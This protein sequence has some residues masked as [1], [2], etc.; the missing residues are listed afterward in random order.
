M[1]NALVIKGVSF[2]TNALTTISYGG[3]VPCTALSLNQSSVTITDMSAYTLTA[4]PTPSNTSDTVSWSSSD[5]N[6]ATVAD[7]VVTPVR[8]GSVT[9]TATCGTQTAT[10]AFTIRQYLN[11]G[12]TYYYYLGKAT[13]ADGD[14]LNIEGGT[15]T[16][17]YGG[18][19]ITTGTG[20]HARDYQNYLSGNNAYPIALPTN[21]T[22]V[23]ITVPYQ[24]IKVT[25]AWC[26]ST[27]ASGYGSNDIRCLSYEGSPWTS[28]V[29]AGNR[30]VSVP[31]VS[32]IDCFYVNAYR[33]TNDGGLSQTVLD[34]VTVEALFS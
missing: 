28:S 11:A 19:I 10:C 17:T 22:S 3:N 33:S 2:S 1:G 32:G 25:I 16:T 20:K 5:T 12:M 14:S 13:S 9:I 34:E 4:T 29:S 7:G 30:T 21:C 23:A 26:S 18:T 31:D 15:S 6:V 27:M 24:N 8:G